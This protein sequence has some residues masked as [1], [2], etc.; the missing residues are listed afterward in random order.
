MK[1]RVADILMDVIAENGITDCFAV[2]G[3]GAMHI[4][5]ALA[6]RKDMRKVFC[7]HE[8]A[9]AMAAEGYAKACGKMALV[10]VTSGPGA[11]NTYNG[12][13]GA[14]ADSVPM[15][16]LAGH[17]RLDTTV[18]P[19][20]LHLRCRG[21]Q[22]FDS[23]S[24]VRG[25]TKYA[26]LITDPLAVRMEVQKAIDI[27]MQGR[28]GPVWLSVPLDVQGAVVDTDELYECE[29]RKQ[30]AYTLDN[31]IFDKL[32]ALL[33]DAKRPCI[34]TG[35]GIRTGNAVEAFEKWSKR[36][37][38]PIVGGA[39]QAD[40][41]YEGAPYYYGMS[42]SV[43]PRKG[44]FILQN[45]DLIL[46]LGNSLSTKQ[47]GFQQ[48]TFACGAKIVMVDAESDEMKKPGLRIALSIYAD[49]DTFFKAAADLVQPW[50]P[51][52]KWIRYCDNLDHVLGDIDTG[53][54]QADQEKL[55][56]NTFWDAFR[57]H[58]KEDAVIALGN[59]SCI[60]G[61]LQKG[62]R[63][64][65]QRVIVNY[66]SGS[67]GDDLPEA[68]GAALALEREIICVTGD[69]SFM[70]N[71]QEL[72]TIRHY[73]LPVKIVVFSNDGYG[74]IRQTNKNFFNGLYIGCDPDSGVSFPDFGKVAAA[75]DFPFYRCHN[76]GMLHEGIG[77]L[78]DEEQAAILEVIQ[79]PDD[80]PL[81]KVMSKMRE[82]GSFYTP[83]LHDMYPFLDESKIR[84]LM[85]GYNS[86]D[87]K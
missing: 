47:T 10:C 37:H 68:V 34:L 5:N 69:G 3:G 58:M 36:M 45:A 86:E 62:I 71:L 17:P 48:E 77:W 35:S 59:S 32:N 49:L 87:L 11:I 26:K 7:H 65:Q 53:R 78:L 6:L 18:P 82:D 21:V 4:D 16:V 85:I 38:I 33:A 19:T 52:E 66:N 22:E 12:V 84:E 80:R 31:K 46:V 29:Q 56:Q 41:L 30:P 9:C 42:G 60:L 1:K 83:P 64:R 55:S 28:R 61:I 40:I 24:A 25:M 15:L 75:F 57:K 76:C 27:A 44:N 73:H 43:G 79:T 14:W 50:K 70:M 8:Q 81:P 51:D 2:V 72:Q 13:E 74:A 63:S 54:I 39:L 20:G 67:M 23:V